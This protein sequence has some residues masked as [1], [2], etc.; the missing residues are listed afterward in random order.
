M[1]KLV[2]LAVMFALATTPVYARGSHYSSHHSAHRSTH[3]SSHHRSHKC[4]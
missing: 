4:C 3:H 1:R 2:Y